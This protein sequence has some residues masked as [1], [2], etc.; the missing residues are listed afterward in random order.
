MKIQKKIIYFWGRKIYAF[1]Y[2]RLIIYFFRFFFFNNSI[3]FNY[4]K[5]D[6]DLPKTDLFFSNCK[7]L[8]INENTKLKLSIS[9]ELQAEINKCKYVIFQDNL[10]N[11]IKKEINNKEI[12]INQKNFIMD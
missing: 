1:T 12:I 10:L 7:Y 11:N 5:T 4:I 3:L 6:N 2:F 8:V 9:L